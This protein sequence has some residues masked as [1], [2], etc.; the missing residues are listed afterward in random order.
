MVQRKRDIVNGLDLTSIRVVIDLEVTHLKD[1]TRTVLVSGLGCG[2]G[3]CCH[4]S[5]QTRRRNRGLATSS[6]PAEIKK[7]PTN[8]KTIITIGGINHHHRPFRSDEA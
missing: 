2:G 7:S 5:D 4:D 8:T 3:G 6:N 1:G